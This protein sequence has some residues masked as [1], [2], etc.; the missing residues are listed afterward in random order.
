MGYGRAMDATVVFRLPDGSKA[1]LT[2]GDLVGRLE[3]A[4][5]HIDDPRVSE[6]HAMVSL[7][8]AA[9]K[10]VALRGRIA[11][12]G[13]PLRDV[14]LSDGLVVH[15]APDFALVVE[16]VVLPEEVLGVSV[17]D[18]GPRVVTGVCSLTAD[19]A[20]RAGYSPDARAWLWPQGDCFVLRRPDVVDEVLMLGG[21]VTVD[22]VVLAVGVIGMGGGR[23]FATTD[24]G[25]A[26]AATAPLELV[27][28][29]TSVHIRRAGSRT[30]VIAGLAARVLSEL[31]AA[32]VPMPWNALAKEIWS[33]TDSDSELRARW[34]VTM[35]RLRKKLVAA[36]LR[37]DLVRSDRHGNI[38]LCLGEG[39]T[40]RDE[41]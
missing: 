6:A 18:E 2:H 41:S 11:V 1:T 4:A 7:R 8:G 26:S 31:I 14:E 32:G 22:E 9:M 36:G 15:L 29:Y 40:A 24:H 27:A 10:L 5:L 25:L 21:R 35:S 23:S 38:E 33:T 20:L 3:T 13:F 16:R 12:D 19:G 30:L 39:D 28:N 37:A 17:G 34:D